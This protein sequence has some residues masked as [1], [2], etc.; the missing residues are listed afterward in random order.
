MRKE[1][2]S[3]SGYYLLYL[4]HLI[5]FILI[6]IKLIVQSKVSYKKMPSDLRGILYLK[7]VNTIVE[8]L[9]LHEALVLDEVIKLYDL[10]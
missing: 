5:V 10:I 9:S 6:Y 2:K 7:Y 4:F 8:D 3:A 1:P